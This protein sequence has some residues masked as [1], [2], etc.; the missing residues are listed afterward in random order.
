VVSTT[1]GITH[2][3]PPPVGPA[4]THTVDQLG[5]TIDGII[6]APPPRVAL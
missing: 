3:L 2:K 1:A 4:A 6:G 5:K